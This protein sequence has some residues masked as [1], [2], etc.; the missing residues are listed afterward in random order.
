MKD[1]AAGE[2][3]IVYAPEVEGR[4]FLCWTDENDN[5]LGYDDSYGMIVN[6]NIIV[7]AV[8]GEVEIEKKPVIAMTNVFT[9]SLN[10]KNKL[11]FTATRDIPE[12]YTVIEH[13]ILYRAWNEESAPS[14]DAFVF[15][16]TGMKKYVSAD[17]TPSGVFTLN[18]NITGKE[19]VAIAA[20]GYMIVKHDVTGQEEIYYTNISCESYDSISHE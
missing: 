11:S 14:E 15:G 6:K 5:I 13:G 3:K 20:R 17:M 9:S 1:V 7:K 2:G 10:G 12:G 18:I 19:S 8:Y 4:V 16:E